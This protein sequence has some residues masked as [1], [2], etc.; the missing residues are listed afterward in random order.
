MISSSILVEILALAHLSNSGLPSRINIS[1]IWKPKED[2]KEDQ[3]FSSL[4]KTCYLLRKREE[5]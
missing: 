1:K 4:I 5:S 3:T 2:L